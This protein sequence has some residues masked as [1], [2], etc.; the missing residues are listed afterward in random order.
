MESSS[1]SLESFRAKKCRVCGDKA[2][3]KRKCTNLILFINSF[4]L[5]FNFSGLSC[6]SCKSFFRRNA[7]R[8]VVSFVCFLNVFLK[9]LL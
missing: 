5:A 2:I 3:G 9:L 4:F 7:H 6:E 8:Q 1:S